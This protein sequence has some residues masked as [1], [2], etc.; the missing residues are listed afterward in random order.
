MSD[1]LQLKN[2]PLNKYSQS[3]ETFMREEITKLLNAGL[4]EK[5]PSPVFSSPSVA[6]TVSLV[7]LEYI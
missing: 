4:I 1:F 6:S 5:S 7:H 3:Q 2:R